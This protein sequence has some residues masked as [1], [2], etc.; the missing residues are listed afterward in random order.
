MNYE[1]DKGEQQK[2]ASE[3]A[4]SYKMSIRDWKVERWETWCLNSNFL[5]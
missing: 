4:C 3:W 1:M 2:R 5:T